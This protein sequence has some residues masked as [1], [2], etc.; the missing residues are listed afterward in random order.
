MERRWEDSAL[1]TNLNKWFLKDLTSRR[2]QRCYQ[3]AW[4][5]TLQKLCLV[6]QPGTVPAARKLDW[7]S[8]V[9]VFTLTKSTKSN[10]VKTLLSANMASNLR[11]VCSIGPKLMSRPV[12]LLPRLV[13]SLAATSSSSFKTAR[14]PGGVHA[15]LEEANLPTTTLYQTV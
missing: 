8:T 12:K 14:V 13:V 4:S 15:I 7:N 6:V 1:Q 11:R 9:E 3:L 10:N 2:Y 5:I